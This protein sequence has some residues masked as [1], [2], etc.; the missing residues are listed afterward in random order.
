ME[1]TERSPFAALEWVTGRSVREGAS[2]WMGRA[3]QWNLLLSVKGCGRVDL[4]EGG[5]DLPQGSLALIAAGPKREFSVEKGWDVYWVHFRREET[6]AVARWPEVLRGVHLVT[7]PKPVFD[8]ARSAFIELHGYSMAQPPGW[9]P[10]A[11]CLLESVILRGNAASAHGVSDLRL[12]RARDLLETLDGF[13]GLD[14][15]AAACGLSRSTF[16]S[17]FKKAYGV[18]PRG[19]REARM[20]RRSLELMDDERLSLGEI[21]ARIGMPNLFYFSAR[22]KKVYGCAP[23]KYRGRA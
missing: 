15:V 12:E 18:S 16:F 13:G 5:V 21:A 7:A 3:N 17:R 22:F 8:A 23:S 10:L 9:R 1:L 14:G 6:G 20:L 2:R 19:Y 4:E 11:L